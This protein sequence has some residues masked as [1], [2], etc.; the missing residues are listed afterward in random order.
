MGQF[1]L[2]YGELVLKQEDP[3]SDTA[4]LDE[5]SA[6][7]SETL[8]S[9]ISEYL[10]LQHNHAAKPPAK[11]QK[12]SQTKFK[13]IRPKPNKSNV[14]ANVITIYVDE[15]GQPIEESVI[16]E[17]NKLDD[18]QPPLKDEN[19]LSV[20]SEY[21]PSASPAS[22]LGYESLGSPNSIVEDIW[23]PCVSEL[24]PSLMFLEL[25]SLKNRPRRSRGRVTTERQD[26]FVVQIGRRNSTSHPEIQRQLLQA[27]GES[28]SV[29]TSEKDFALGNY[30]AEDS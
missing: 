20:P 10:L 11:K 21:T 30:L 13:A 8:V 23:D 14:S 4:C 12:T 28:V 19:L 15:N 7:E 9:D 2:I 29:E 5:T 26:R 22:D 6:A 24:F 18:N 16:D 1:L 27:T 3:I 25:G 17:V